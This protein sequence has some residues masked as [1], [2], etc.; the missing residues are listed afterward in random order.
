LSYM[1]RERKHTK[2]EQLHKTN[3][4]DPKK[5]IDTHTHSLSLTLTLTH[6][7][8]HSHAHTHTH[9]HTL[10]HSHTNDLPTMVVVRGDVCEIHMY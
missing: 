10:T 3:T 1:H 7:F 6:S 9:T 4:D 5:V 2:N 8:T